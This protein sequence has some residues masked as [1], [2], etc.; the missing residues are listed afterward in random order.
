MEEFLDRIKRMREKGVVK[1]TMRGCNCGLHFAGSS[2][3]MR[4]YA[5]D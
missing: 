4:G 1:M 5:N 2:C 3:K